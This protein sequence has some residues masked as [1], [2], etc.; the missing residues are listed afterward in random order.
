MTRSGNSSFSIL[1]SI[2]LLYLILIVVAIFFSNQLLATVGSNAGQESPLV[3]LLA[4]LFPSTL[5]LALGVQVLR[6]VHQLRQKKPGIQFKVRLVL[7]LSAMSLLAIIPQALLFSNF[8]SSMVQT[9]LVRNTET[10]LTYGVDL[11]VS[12]YSAHIQDLESVSNRPLRDLWL[13]SGDSPETSW[14]KVQSLPDPPDAMQIFLPGGSAQFGLES[15]WIDKDNASALATDQITKISNNQG[16]IFRYRISQPGSA[17]PLVLSRLV[18]TGLEESAR[19]LSR[20]RDSFRSFMDIET[21]IIPLVG[22][23]YLIFMAPLLLISLLT[24]FFLSDEIIR[25]LVNLEATLMRISQGEFNARMTIR[26]GDE[27]GF[28]VNSFNRMMTE[29]NR[30]RENARQ[31][32]RLQ[33]WQDIAQRMAHE[34]KNPLTPIKLS[35]QRIQKRYEENNPELERIIKDSVSTIVQEVDN[36][37]SMLTEFR[38]F[39]RLPLPRKELISLKPLIQ[40]VWHMYEDQSRVTL[41]LEGV[42]VNQDLQADPGQ[43]RQVFKNFFQNSID[44]I[45]GEGSIKVQADQLIREG[46]E[47]VRI[48][49]TDSGPGIPDDQIKTI[50]QPYFTTKKHGNGLGLAIVEKIVLDHGGELWCEATGGQGACFVMEVPHG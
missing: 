12:R 29:L 31:N 30:N 49:I 8:L 46:Q 15:L 42:E 17:S 47:M 2:V 10:A 40:D 18:D 20:S 13:V 4:F 14:D 48:Q 36:L 23:M 41:F 35:A 25:P 11:A 38:N 50:F 9:D 22:F 28:L 3:Y 19:L 26:R 32:E 16:T 5:A 34:I 27:M 24:G 45:P 43:L 39:A 37:A 44:A 33:A 6:L 21:S 1:I 7:F